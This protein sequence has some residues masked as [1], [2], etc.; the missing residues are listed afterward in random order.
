MRK[1]L[2]GQ[3]HWAEQNRLWETSGLLQQKYCEQQGLSYRQLIYWR[4]LAQRANK[5]FVE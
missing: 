3:G 2:V 4:G 1:K 5:Q